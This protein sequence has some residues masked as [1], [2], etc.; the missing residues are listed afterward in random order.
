VSGA[1]R[2]LSLTT[3]FCEANESFKAYKI[4]VHRHT[5]EMEETLGIA[6][7]KPVQLTFVP[8]LVPVTRGML[9]TIYADTK[10]NVSPEDIRECLTTY[11]GKRFFVRI[12][13]EKSFPDISHV[14]G[15]NYIDIGLTG[16]KK[17]NRIVLVSVIDNLVKGA[18][19]QAVQNMNIM[20]GLDEATGLT[21]SPF[22]V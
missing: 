19:G 7:G 5:P 14:R 2:S 10:E 4:G 22:P 13:P 20:S 3:H 12:Y 17:T 18:A 16:I 6:A 11:Y 21:H 15:T 8:H 1:G 9:T